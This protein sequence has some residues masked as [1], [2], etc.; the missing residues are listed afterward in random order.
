MNGCERASRRTFAHPSWNAQRNHSRAHPASAS[1]RRHPGVNTSYLLSPKVFPSD[2]SE[3]V[4][5]CCATEAPVQF[6]SSGQSIGRA[7]RDAELRDA[8]ASALFAVTTR[9]RLTAWSKTHV[10]MSRLY[11][12]VRPS[13][14]GDARNDIPL[15]SEIHC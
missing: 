12:Q 8:N 10:I 7:F 1:S 6:R 11:T 14:E 15:S 5:L 3:N 9:T 4:S 13:E 2:W